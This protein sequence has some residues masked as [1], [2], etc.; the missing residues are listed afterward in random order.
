LLK[1]ASNISLRVHLH[2]SHGGF[3]A[4]HLSG[5][6]QSGANE[7]LT[8]KPVEP[9]G[10]P[11]SP[12][13]RRF[14]AGL[15]AATAAASTGVLAPLVAASSASARETPDLAT[16]SD[17]GAARSRNGLPA[18]V[19][20][21]RLVQAFSIRVGEATQDAL[22]GPAVNVN[23][24]D[25]ARYLDQGGTYT[26]GLPHDDFGRVD[27]QAFATFTDALNSGEFSD[28]QKIVVG[29]TRTL[30]GPQGGLAFNLEAL[31]NV[32]FGQPQVPPAP[33]TAS[34]QNATE[35]LEHYWASLLRDVAFTDYSSSGL[36]VAAAVELGSQPTY[37]GPRSGGKVTPNLL[38]RG[39]FPGE[40]LGPYI[41]QFF[42][43]PTALGAQ[44]MSQQM[45]SYQPDIDYMYS[46]GDWLTVQDGNVTGLKNQIDP[47]L[48]YMRNGRDL[49][50]FTHVDVL[51]QAYFTALLVLGTIGAPVNPGNP[52]VGSK[53]ENGFGTFGAPDFAGTLTEVAT[54]ALNA[55]W[56][57]KWFV[58]LR[59][60]PEAIG[61]I[62]HLIMT[63]Q[64][65]KTDVT[66]SN[67][68]LSS[69]GLQQSFLKYGTW[70]LS[71]A[72]PEGSPTH[73]SYPTGHGVVGG[74][75]ITVLKF[76]FDGNFVI[77]NPKVPSDDGLS[78]LDYT[79]A[80]AGQLTVNGEL[81]KLGHNVSFGHGIHAGIHWR[82]DTDTSL[83]LGE[84]VALSCLKDRARTYNEPFTVHLTKFDGTTATIS[85]RG[86]P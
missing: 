57:Q 82:S 46:F 81:N 30:N 74:A 28:F 62:V 55:V 69:I 78:L 12:G 25:P 73:P 13:R 42:I 20:H 45:T 77:P 40:A 84:A 50:A 58:H 9:S 51:Y 54:K 36:A 10:A 80:D 44:P 18:G 39:A 75:C 33:K 17:F 65:N 48:R 1:A 67:V 85:N 53:T 60:R 11:K 63:G 7:N 72:F 5:K 23:N 56:Y 32:Q 35:L 64:S 14:I 4:K 29:G 49:S 22:V 41:S 76:F 47:Q 31:D 21:D 26:K 27:L 19:T 59:P 24:G 8:E 83:L 70:L 71:Q 15:G 52:Y 61:G 16:Q 86:N 66:L 6:H 38:F 79:G 37:F 68:I 43:K 2:R 3:L 34:D